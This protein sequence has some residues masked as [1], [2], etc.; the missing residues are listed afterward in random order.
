MNHRG[1]VTT[2]HAEQ[3]SAFINL[4]ALLTIDRVSVR[5][6]IRCAPHLA[7]RGFVERRRINVF[8]RFTDEEA[9]S[10][11]CSATMIR[12]ADRWFRVPISD[13]ECHQLPLLRAELGLDPPP[14]QQSPQ[15]N[16]RKDIAA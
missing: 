14:S 2:A 9:R 12:A 8:P 13:L 7:Q 4:E 11:S 3:G 6:R 1:D 5:H 16:Q 15:T 10:S